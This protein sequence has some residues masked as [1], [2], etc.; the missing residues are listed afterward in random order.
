MKLYV[1]WQET[2]KDAIIMDIT[3]MVE[4]TLDIQPNLDIIIIANAIMD[5]AEA[6]CVITADTEEDMFSMFP[7]A[8][9]RYEKDNLL[10]EVLFD[11]QQ[12]H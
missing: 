8:K 12:Y 2:N 4:E 10:S 11:D 3:S 5:I 1:M 7:N 6:D 9:I